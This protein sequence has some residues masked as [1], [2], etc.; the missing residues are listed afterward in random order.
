MDILSTTWLL[1]LGFG[2]GLKHAI[3]A[4]HLA[5][6]ST[7]VS[8]R[9]SVWSA[10]LVGGLWGIGHTVSL[11]I[12]GVM[13][14]L[15]RFEISDRM[16]LALEFCVALALVALGTDSL[17]KVA[18]AGQ[19]HIHIHR[20][21]NKLHAHPH[22]HDDSTVH[23]PIHD[24]DTKTHSHHDIAFKARPLIVGMI[25]GFAGSGAVMLLVL[26]TIASRPVGLA[27]IFIF[28]L[29]SVGG[30]ILMTMLVGLPLQLTANRYRWVEWAV[31]A[32]SGL[33]SL[34]FG[35]FLAYDISFS[36]ALFQR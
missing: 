1:A 16:A 23:E 20:H 25:H 5:A 3:E 11:F 26:S 7:I 8:E 36:H 32:A 31:R 29:G 12:A 28:G 6:V 15:F 9:K 22:L 30:M 33:F 13:V 34:G 27:Y 2:L 10:S 35:L 18:R 14:M 19:L 4:D 21:G 17:R 24:E